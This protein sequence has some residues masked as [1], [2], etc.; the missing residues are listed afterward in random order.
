MQKIHKILLV[1][2]VVLGLPGCAAVTD[3]HI[4]QSINDDIRLEGR[5]Q[6][7][8][9]SD[10]FIRAISDARLHY[11]FTASRLATDKDLLESNEILAE[12]KSAVRQYRKGMETVREN[13]EDLA[14]KR[15]DSAAMSANAR[16]TYLN[17]H[18]TLMESM[19]Q[20]NKKTVRMN[21]NLLDQAAFAI[22]VLK[23]SE[24]DVAE[25]RIIFAKSK[26]EDKYADRLR[27]FNQAA[28][29][30]EAWRKKLASHLVR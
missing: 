22:L 25:G 8:F 4:T 11:L 9:V 27:R 24:W 6:A 13:L 20:F 29:D 28:D 19:R 21:R 15:T 10:R 23:R 26:D 3:L 12:S 1:S 2:L 30:Y 5:K 16:T 7:I 18:S 14:L 17:R